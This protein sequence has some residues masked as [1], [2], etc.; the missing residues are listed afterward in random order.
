[1]KERP[2]KKITITKKAENSVL[3]N[4]PWIYG[5]EIIQKEEIKNGEIVDVLNS[6]GKYLGTGFYNDHS[7]IT[8]RLLS[9]NTNDTFDY[10]F[11]KRRVKYAYDLRKQTIQDLNSF[12]LIYGEADGFPG[13][14]VDKFNDVL[15]TQTLSLG[16]ETRKEMVFK[17]LL[18]VLQE[19]HINIKGIYERNDVD[20]R[21]LEGLE[22]YKGWYQN[23]SLETR[24]EI[25]E[26]GLHYIVDFENGQKTGYFLDQKYNRLKVREFAKGKTVLDCCTHTGS[27]AMNAYL[28]GALKVTALDVSE[29]ALEDT[30]T[31]F[32]K[33]HMNIETICKDVFD[34]LTEIEGKKQYDFIILDPPA[35]TKSRKTIHQALKGYEEL[36]YLAMK[37]LP[38]GGLLATASCSHF[39]KEERFKEA[40]WNASR[41]ANV[42]L[43]QIYVAGPAPDHPE[44]IGV[45]ETKYLKFFI[46]QVV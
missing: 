30:K 18:E 43:K 8:V 1:M 5:E 19:D 6:K 44:L 20:V 29:K 10:D 21:T 23:K 11:F 9:R 13:L 15:V 42:S 45:P 3:L 25:T 41:K 17:A 38:R 4:H 2:Y 16:I 27:F 12:R 39:A 22:K 31:N 40:I 33:N 7:K 37:A 35:F 26:N 28:G 36:N 14:T 32:Q 34:Y 24:T 46:F